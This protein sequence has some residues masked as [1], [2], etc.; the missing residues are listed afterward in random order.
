MQQKNHKSDTGLNI[1][2]R[3]DF[4]TDGADGSSFVNNEHSISIAGGFGKIVLGIDDDA[5]DATQDVDQENMGMKIVSGDISVIVSQG[6][7]ESNDED[8]KNAGAS[9][10]YKMPNGMTVGAY[11]FKSEDDLD[12]GE[13]YSRSGAEIQYTIASGLTAVINVDDYD[14]KNGTSDAA[15]ADSGTSS[16][17]TIK[18]AF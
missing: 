13:E 8:I 12:A 5:G 10:S 2:Y 11:T 17:L 14:Y 18:A 9:I 16:K 1:T 4:H 7:T 6:G 3:A 15:N